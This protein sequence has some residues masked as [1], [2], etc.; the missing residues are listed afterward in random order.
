MRKA[1]EYLVGMHDFKSV[2]GNPKMKKS[3]VRVIYDIE[4]KQNGPYIRLYFHGNGFLQH[5]VR[6]M[7]GTLLEA[8]FGRMEPEEMEKILAGMERRLA[9]PTAPPQGLCMMKVDY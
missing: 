5:M 7:T 4:I 1:A 6:I 3:T 2:C 9:G 8:G